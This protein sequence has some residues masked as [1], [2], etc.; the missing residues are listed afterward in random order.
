MRQR[1]RER[2]TTRDYTLYIY[3][4]KGNLL[5]F[6]FRY[7]DEYY[8]NQSVI[9]NCRSL[10]YVVKTRRKTTTNRLLRVALITFF[11]HIIYKTRVTIFSLR[12]FVNRLY[13]FLIILIVNNTHTNVNFDIA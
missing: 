5:L 4:I 6:L 9:I 8:N 12:L 10:T 1:E 11:L 13:S 3:K 7:I 2:N